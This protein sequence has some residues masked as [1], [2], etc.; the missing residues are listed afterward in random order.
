VSGN[1][2][3]M[4]VKL[5][6]ESQI[7]VRKIRLCPTGVPRLYLAMAKPKRTAQDVADGAARSLI[8][9]DKHK[10]MALS[11]ENSTPASPGAV[12]Q[13]PRSFR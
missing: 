12:N 7:V 4:G 10:H 2:F 1:A 11:L 5:A 8:D 3:Q 9:M 13:L 6:R